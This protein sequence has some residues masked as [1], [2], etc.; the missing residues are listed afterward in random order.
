MYR[1]LQA[2]SI[3]FLFFYSCDLFS[4]GLDS[5]EERPKIG[6][7]LS[8][9]G[10]KG[11]AHVGVLKSLEQAGIRP[12][13]IVGTSMGAVVGGLYSLGYSA[14]E[15]E[16]IIQRI[17]WGLLISNRV[18][19]KYIAFEEKEYYNRYLL[20]FPIVKGKIAFPSGLIQGQV[21]S[22]I[23]HYYTWP[24]NSYET[25]D[26]F[27]IPFR[28][29][30][31]DI[32]TGQPMIFDRGYLQDALRSSIA[33][34][35]VFSAFELDSTSV[36]D[37]GVVNNFPVDIVRGMGADV[38]IG[39]N[40]SDEDFKEV[41]DLGG[42]GGIL[43]QIAM[44]PSL[45]I[46]KENI[47]A[48]DIYIKPDLEGYSTGS[49]SAYNEILELGK[50]TGEKYFAQFKALA[51]SLE[52]KDVIP[53]LSFQ[54]D[55]IQ[56]NRIEILGNNLFS[57]DLIRSKMNINE[58]EY[59]TRDELE[60][61]V[62]GIYGMNGFYK[63]D[64][65]LTPLGI[66]SYEIL[67]RIKEKPSTLLSTAIHYDN[68]FSAGILL[69]FT[70]REVLGH[71]SRTVVLADVSENPKFRFDYY[72]YTG[73]NK[74]F[75]FNLRANYLRQELPSYI[76]GKESD[77]QIGQNTRVEAQMI[78]TNS[79][80][81]AFYI[82]GV[83]DASK[84]KYR[85]LSSSFDEVRNGRQTYFGGRFKYY[86]NSQNDR[87]YPT[88]G[89]EALLETTL[90]FKDW[91]NFKLNPGVDTIYLDTDEGELPISK[92]VFDSFIE[93]L[94][95]NSYLS[96]YGKYSKFIRIS[97]KL[98]I[99]PELAAGLTLSSEESDKVFSDF[100]VGGYQNVRF[101]DTQFWGLNYAEVQT[102]NFIKFGAGIQYIP[103]NKIY[104]RAGA[105]LLGYS[106]QVS[107]TDPEFF[108]KIYQ[109]DSYFG[110]GLDISYQSILGPISAGIGG[111]NKDK[112]LRSYISIGFSFNYS[113]R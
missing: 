11:I 83:F 66:N 24:A 25:F 101:N 5:Q 20:E 31:T 52:R 102:P 33:I 91:L 63:V 51:D 86:R 22:D 32:R 103:L 16:Q 23:L 44:A 104:L 89:A 29:V 99:R 39:V 82:G 69:N 12:D 76:E 3:L 1:Y 71:N 10:A 59:V 108:N 21:L 84:S 94:V 53:G 6:L 57:T 73:T 109:Q 15:L 92:E 112:A 50:K 61:A 98:Q 34:P 78:S 85:F 26:D 100:F 55:S 60:T 90:H 105:N 107:F 40:V 42:F 19:F 28:C 14:D 37:G 4:Q 93:E 17:D 113:D 79:L 97:S 18:D 64:Y 46:T 77:V 41:D 68:Q 56:I 13:Y 70:A 67:V 96:T 9:G 81:Q 27:P 80:K 43:M 47:E 48:T 49:F 30:A 54:T 45:S 62:H 111:N 58:G 2:L 8:G 65:R 74:K 87:N 88:K 7:V 106:D 95:P 75:A 72:K 110:Y 36:V 35:T 38:V